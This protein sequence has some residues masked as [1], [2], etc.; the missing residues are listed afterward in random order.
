[1]G[2]DG[3][4]D[5]GS[6][7]V[8]AINECRQVKAWVK[9][10]TVHARVQLDVNGETLYAFLLSSLDECVEEFEV[11]DLGFE[12]I[13]K[14]RFERGHFRIHHDDAR[15]DAGTAQ[16][17]SLVSHG[18][19]KIVHAAVLQRLGNFNAACAVG[20]G[21]HH[22]DHLRFRFHEGA[23]V[24]EIPRQGV[25]IDVERGFVNA[26]GE[27]GGDFLK[28]EGSRAFDEH[29]RVVERVKQTAVSEGFAGGEERL[30]HQEE[31]V[32]V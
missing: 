6:L 12:F 28:A 10:Q 31:R 16:F 7:V 19:G 25:E 22:A 11:I 21:F 32:G 8:Q 15:G 27:C 14:E 5:D 2:E 29:E 13:V 26:Q 1:M 30:L 18:D 17:G 4:G 24:V 3:T 20:R 23:I 9:A